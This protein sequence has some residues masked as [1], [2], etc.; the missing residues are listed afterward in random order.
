MKRLLLTIPLVSVLLTACAGGGRQAADVAVYDFGLPAV[1]VAVNGKA[2][3][4]FDLEVSAPTWGESP[5]VDYRLLYDE[6]LKRRSYANNRW[7]GAPNLLLARHLRQQLGME[8]RDEG[9]VEHCRLALDLLEFSQIFSSTRASSALVQV[10]ARLLDARRNPIAVQ[11]FRVEEAAP[12]ANAAGGV[13]AL[14]AA[15]DALALRLSEWLLSLEMGG[16]VGGCLTMKN[17]QAR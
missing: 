8:A 16:G 2:W 13:K 5:Y 15:S 6:Q 3:P 7:A 14:V 9:S 11:A 1:A 17:A 10:N 12:T 4:Q